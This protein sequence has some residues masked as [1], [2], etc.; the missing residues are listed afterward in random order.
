MNIKGI[1]A[2]MVLILILPVAG[3]SAHRLYIDYRIGKIEI[4]SFYG[5]GTPCRDAVVKVYTDKGKLL[6]EGKTDE[7]G[8]YSFSP[9][10]GINKYKVTVQATHMPGH[11]AERMVNL[12]DIGV[13][14]EEGRELPLFSRIIAG[15][16]YLAGIAGASMAYMGWREKK[17]YG[18]EKL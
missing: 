2:L 1:I 8:K 18:K 4:E 16:G 5:G 11:R 12:K 10:I 17:K 15:F 6:Q 14:N 7:E 3:A 9:V 13:S